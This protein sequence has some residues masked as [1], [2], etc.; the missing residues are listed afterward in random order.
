MR[1]TTQFESYP[2]GPAGPTPQTPSSPG[3]AKERQVFG[4]EY[5]K[6]GSVIINDAGDRAR[7]DRVMRNGDDFHIRLTAQDGTA[8]KLTVNAGKRFQGHLPPETTA[9]SNPVADVEPAPAVLPDTR[10]PG[11]F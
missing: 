3:P 9:T 8:G 2:P 5:L 4:V 7:I 10:G 1:G 6:A 11:L